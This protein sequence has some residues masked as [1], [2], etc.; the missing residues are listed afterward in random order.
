MH[1]SNPLGPEGCSSAREK[2]PTPRSWEALRCRPPAGARVRL[3]S[4]WRIAQPDVAQEHL[5]DGEGEGGFRVSIRGFHSTNS[6]PGNMKSSGADRIA[7]W[8]SDGDDGRGSF[9]HRGFF[10]AVRPNDCWATLARSLKAETNVTRMAACRR[11][12]SLPLEPRENGHA[13]LKIVDGRGVESLRFVE[14][15]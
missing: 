12:A 13:A 8:M 14:L 2:V 5:S 6:K 11:T 9:L 4:F 3:H 7:L 1:S 15:G 10:L